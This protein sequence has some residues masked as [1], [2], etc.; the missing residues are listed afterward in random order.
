LLPA[1]IADA[2]IVAAVFNDLSEDAQLQL[3]SSLEL[4]A[5]SVSYVSGL[6]HHEDDD[7]TEHIGRARSLIAEQLVEVDSLLPEKLAAV[8]NE[9]ASAGG[10]T[11]AVAV[12]VKG[13]KREFEQFADSHL[14]SVRDELTRLA[15]TLIADVQQQVATAVSSA[16]ASAR[17]D[18]EQASTA[19]LSSLGERAERLKKEVNDGAERLV[20]RAKQ[21]AR[22]I[23]L[24][25]AQQQF[26]EEAR[27]LNRQLT[28]WSGIA[29]VAL[30]FFFAFGI[31][32]MQH[33]QLP[34]KWTWQVLYYTAIRL[35]LLSAIGAV[36]T[37]AL[38]MVSIHIDRRHL[39]S[40]RA[41]LANS[42]AAFVEAARTEAQQD[43]VLLRLVDSITQR[44]VADE[45]KPSEQPNLGNVNVEAIEKLLE[46]TRRQK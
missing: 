33:Q 4:V 30:L 18:A 20:S 26:R 19:V 25:A 16:A 6:D 10:K 29:T 9:L 40:H 32:I 35:T 17:S 39:N 3:I 12:D 45:I 22:N 42:M 28:V 46:L 38:K 31:W 41:R 8:K 2:R 14:T 36:A 5:E 27:A 34:D 13:A 24:E 21:I 43:A 44:D 1:L 11:F 37:Y 23:S 7:T 15:E